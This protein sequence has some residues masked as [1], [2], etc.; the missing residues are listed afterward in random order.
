MEMTRRSSSSGVG[1]FTLAELLVVLGIVVLL[2]SLLLPTL[3]GAREMSRRT[4][5]MSNM[6]QLTQACLAYAQ[7]HDRQ[8]IFSETGKGGWADTIMNAG[9]EADAIR[10]GTLYPYLNNLDIYRCPDDET[11][12]RSYSINGFLNSAWPEYQPVARLLAQVKNAAQT[13]ALI[14][15]ND[16]RGEN[17]GPFVVSRPPVFVWNDY[18]A[19]WH[20]NGACL[21]FMDGRCEYWQ[22]SDPRTLALVKNHTPSP[23]NPDLARVQQVVGF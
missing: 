21:S 16:R 1:A 18:P 10:H 20:R 12:L 2:V 14:E 6:R 23:N 22:W 5:C 7:D 3:S 8:L 11:H 17:E 4:K 13:F 9:T 15:E 19:T